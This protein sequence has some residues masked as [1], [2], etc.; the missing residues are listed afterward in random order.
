MV[1]EA[2]LHKKHVSKRSKT[3]NNDVQNPKYLN[4]NLKLEVCS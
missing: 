3:L 4:S 2:I 1:I